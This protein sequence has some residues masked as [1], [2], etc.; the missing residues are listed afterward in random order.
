MHVIAAKAVAFAEA[1]QPEFK[2][3]QLQVLLNAKAMARELIRRGYR[4]VSG[5]TE[6]HLLLLDLIDKHIT[7]K[8][9][10]AALSRA[11]ITVNKNAVPNDPLSPF[12]TSGLRL[13]T[14]AVTTRGF[15]EKEMTLI[16]GWIADILDDMNNEHTID[17]VR[18]QV[19]ALC[20]EFPVYHGNII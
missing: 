2:Q 4:I 8:D 9:A 10:D 11:N 13:G 17:R 6:N 19:L 16:T 1:L 3:Y 12:V 7:G 15:K 5:G 18:S 20:R 14:P